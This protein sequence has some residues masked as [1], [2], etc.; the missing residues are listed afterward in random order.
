MS[1]HRELDQAH[2][3]ALADWSSEIRPLVIEHAENARKGSELDQP[4][5]PLAAPARRKWLSWP[6]GYLLQYLDS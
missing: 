1:R 2:D 6:S 4:E 3:A 5:L